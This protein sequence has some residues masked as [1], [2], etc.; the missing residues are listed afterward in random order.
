MR[1]KRKEEKGKRKKGTEEG[2]DCFHMNRSL[3]DCADEKLV[4]ICV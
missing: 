2:H 3:S 4:F 1:K